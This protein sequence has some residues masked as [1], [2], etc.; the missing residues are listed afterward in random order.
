MAKV[1]MIQ[2]RSGTY[3]SPKYYFI[4]N[5][6]IYCKGRTKKQD[7]PSFKGNTLIEIAAQ[8]YTINTKEANWS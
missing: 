1:K 3:Y 6:L 7:T 5:K 8:S 2:G 4:D